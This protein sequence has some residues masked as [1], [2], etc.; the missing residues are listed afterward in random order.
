MVGA[1]FH[2]ALALGV[3]WCG[4][5]GPLLAF[6][7]DDRGGRIGFCVARV[8]RGLFDSWTHGKMSAKEIEA[9]AMDT[10]VEMEVEE[11]SGLKIIPDD[12][13]TSVSQPRPVRS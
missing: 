12:G 11:P 5:R 7:R 3:E 2:A 10:L 13:P 8:R 4:C 6:R 9:N 1:P